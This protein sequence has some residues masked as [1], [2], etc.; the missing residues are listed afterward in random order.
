MRLG[1][2]GCNYKGGDAALCQITLDTCSLC[3]PLSSSVD[4]TYRR[5]I[6]P[7][8]AVANFFKSGVWE[9]SA[10]IFGDNRISF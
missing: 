2:S 1:K 7:N 5:S 10:L 6:G 9:G 8:Y 4:N 3:I